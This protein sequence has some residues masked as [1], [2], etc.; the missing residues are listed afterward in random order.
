[1]AVL[2]AHE[3]HLG[4]LQESI[5]PRVA[6]AALGLD[7]PAVR[8]GRSN[9]RLLAIAQQRQRTLPFQPLSGGLRL[10]AK[11]VGEWPLTNG[12]SA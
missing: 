8:A 11:G 2:F 7:R 6:A 5:Q 3:F 12:G 10:T 1:M 4:D 9:G